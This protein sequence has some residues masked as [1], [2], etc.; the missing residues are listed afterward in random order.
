[1]QKRVDKLKQTLFISFDLI[2]HGEIEK[3]LAIATILSYLKNDTQLQDTMSFQ[4][5]SINSL[6]YGGQA[7]P[8]DFDK[9]LSVFNLDRFDF[10]AISAYIWNE[11]FLN[12]FIKYLRKL[13]FRGKIILGG[14]QITYSDQKTLPIQYPDT[15]IFV[16]GYAEQSLKEIFTAIE[17]IDDPLFYNS[18]VDFSLIPSAYLTS[19]IVVPTNTSML[20]LE[21]KRGCPYRCSFCAHRD[22]TQNKVFKHPLEK[23]FKEVAFINDKKVKRV[24]I[25]DPIFNA[26]KEHLEIMR[27]I[28][29]I[30]TTT[31]YTLQSRFENIRGLAG[32]EFLD[33]CEAGNY[34]LEFGLQT[35]DMTESENINRRNNLQQIG[36]AITKLKEQEISY[37]VSLIYG[38]PGQTVD[39]FKRSIDFIE[40]RGCKTIKA[41]PLML[42]R[43]TELFHEKQ[44]W[45]IKEEATGE[46][47]IPVVTS[48]NTFTRNEWEQM[49]HIAKSL[50]PNGRQ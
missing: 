20:R 9:Y 2:R 8:N 42:L 18:T 45:G 26:G 3:P 30:N 32:T 1:L 34:H 46:F 24:N 43:G 27:E 29:R 50:T 49:D 13:G 22:L 23:V 41:Y 16:S 10:I 48:S 17:T 44:K 21:T 7:R 14:Y 33:L 11:Y 36:E 4:H 47:N 15:Q 40:S 19:E 25:L 39:S 5:L 6:K 38:L 37:E 28:N 35:T 31:T 12:D